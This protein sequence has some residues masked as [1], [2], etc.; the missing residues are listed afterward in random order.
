MRVKT[1]ER[2]KV[3]LMSKQ[4]KEKEGLQS[5]PKHRMR[6]LFFSVK[7]VS[8]AYI[9][10]ESVGYFVGISLDTESWEATVNPFSVEAS[11]V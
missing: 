9:P 5:F 1:L 3:D 7:Q 8:R 10:Q 2:N 6:R 11:T 4:L